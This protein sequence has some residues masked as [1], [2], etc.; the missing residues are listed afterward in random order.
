MCVVLL[1]AACTPSV[2]VPREKFES[3]KEVEDAPAG[4]RRVGRFQGT[5]A[6][7]GEAGLQQARETARYRA[8][9]AGATHVVA[10]RE[11][12]TPDSTSAAVDAYDCN[13]PR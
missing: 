5:S 4:C 2:V 1:L 13:S 11:T 10:G 9:G 8:A 12:P 6:L 3:L 7:P